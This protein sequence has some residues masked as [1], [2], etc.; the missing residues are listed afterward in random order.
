MVFDLGFIIVFIG[1]FYFALV[2][3]SLFYYCLFYL[4]NTRDPQMFFKKMFLKFGKIHRNT[5][6]PESLFKYSYMLHARDFTVLKR[7]Q[8]YMFSC[9]FCQIFQNIHFSEYLQTAA[10]G[11]HV[12]SSFNLLN[13]S[14]RSLCRFLY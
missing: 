10:C 6:M 14:Y 2:C 11:I 8:H 13:C 5:I 1:S 3:Y 12:H 9:G 4:F 7:L